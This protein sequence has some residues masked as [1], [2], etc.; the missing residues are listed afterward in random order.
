MIKQIFIILFLAILST[1][2]FAETSSLSIDFVIFIDTSL[3]MVDAIEEAK[4]FVAGEIVGR[5]TEPGDW[6]AL[7]KF[8]GKSELLWQGY[9]NSEAEVAPLVRKL[10]SVKADGRFTDIGS[11]LDVMEGV[12]KDRALPDRPKYILL[13]TDERDRKSVV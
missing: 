3:S 9:I 10:N 4:Q 7:Y 1:S 8:Y 13:I 5:L 2:I 11:A 6:L 12:L